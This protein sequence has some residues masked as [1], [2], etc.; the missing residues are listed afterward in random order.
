METK[1]Q[2]IL[3]IKE[4]LDEEQEIVKLRKIIKIHN[5]RKKK[6]T[7]ELVSVMK[8]NTI[9]C[10]D[11]N[12]GTLLYKQS[13]SKKGINSKMLLATLQNYFKNDS[14]QAETLTKFILDNREE[15]VRETIKHKKE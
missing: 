8:E 5:D 3:K 7:Q 12:G 1:E 15:T 11:I 4:W 9:D 2:L 13:K 10:F 14:T 6:M